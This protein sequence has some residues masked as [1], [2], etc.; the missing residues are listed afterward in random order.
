MHISGRSALT[1]DQRSR[2]SGV[3]SEIKEES[4]KIPG[5]GKKEQQG[6]EQKENHASA[7]YVLGRMMRKKRGTSLVSL[8]IVFLPAP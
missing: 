1:S 2:K 6:D 5:N 4:E 8:R 7:G 3:L